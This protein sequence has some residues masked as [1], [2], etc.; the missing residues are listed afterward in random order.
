MTRPVFGSRAKFICIG[1]ISPRFLQIDSIYGGRMTALPQPINLFEFDNS[2][3]SVCR[4]KNMTTSPAAPRTRSASIGIT[5]R[6]A[7]WALRARVLRD[8]SKLGSVDHGAGTKVSLP[9]LIAPCGGHKRAHPTASSPP[10]APRRRAAGIMAVSAN[11][12]TSFEEL[13][14]A[15]ADTCGFRCI[16]SAIGND[17]GVA[18]PCQGSGI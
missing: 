6:S 2:P 4:K 1:F 8:V 18:R 14:K 13:A 7:S 11:S 15:A 5:A 17:S 12:N 16:P 3:K 10:I 9:V